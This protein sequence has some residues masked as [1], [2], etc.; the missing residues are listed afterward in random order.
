MKIHRL[1]HIHVYCL[2]PDAGMRLRDQRASGPPGAG[3]RGLPPRRHGQSAGFEA[4]A[5]ELDQE[6][7]A[8]SPSVPQ[9]CACAAT[10]R[11]T[12]VGCAGFG[13]R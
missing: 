5:R 13:C 7:D 4:L 6:K 2:D 1:D 9:R 11:S 10:V 3:W 8:P 12:C